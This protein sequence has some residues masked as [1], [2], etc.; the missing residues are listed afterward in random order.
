MAQHAPTSLQWWAESVLTVTGVRWK[1]PSDRS[2]NSLMACLRSRFARSWR[3]MSP[4]HIIWYHMM[5][6]DVMWY[7]VMYNWPASW[8]FW[9]QPSRVCAPFQRTQQ[10]SSGQRQTSECWQGNA[11]SCGTSLW[12]TANNIMWHNMTSHDI[13]WHIDDTFESGPETS[14]KTFKLNSR[15]FP[16]WSSRSSVVSLCSSI[17]SIMYQ[18]VY[19]VNT[20]VTALST[21]GSKSAKSP[22]I[23]YHMMS[24]DIT[25]YMFKWITWRAQAIM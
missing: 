15:V 23:W 20:L 13:I 10:Q 5:Q 4:C 22:V 18:L 11:G 1:R 3:L 8:S 16:A 7:N 19:S 2:A 25:W 6:C 24:G 17:R 14:V 12:C 9:R 21:L